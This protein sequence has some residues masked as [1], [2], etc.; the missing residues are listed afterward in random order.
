MG[1]QARPEEDQGGDSGD[2]SGESRGR[3]RFNPETS[4][5]LS[6]FEFLGPKEN[7][8]IR[9]SK[10]EAQGLEV[11]LKSTQDRLV[12]ELKIPLVY[13]NEHPYAVESRAGA[14]IGIEVESSMPQRSQFAQRG[15]EEGGRGGFGRG[16]GGGRGF[17]GGGRGGMRGGGMRGEGGGQRP[18]GGTPTTFDF[19]SHV[20]LAKK[21]H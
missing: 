2:L 9:V 7:D 14:A 5:A 18:G 11:E 12:Y 6:E 21:A 17:G 3:G 20:Q 1:M 13:S 8:R 4:L 19:W 16:G 10:L 15:G